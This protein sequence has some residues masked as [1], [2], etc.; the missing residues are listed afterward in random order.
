[1]LICKSVRAHSLPTRKDENQKISRPFLISV[2]FSLMDILCEA[3]YNREKWRCVD[4]EVG[5]TAYKP[6]DAGGGGGVCGVCPL[7]S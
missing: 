4:E 3:W 2:I 6:W 7:S 5:T 1:M